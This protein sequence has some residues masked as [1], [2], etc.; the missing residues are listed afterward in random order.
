MLQV[1]EAALRVSVQAGVPQRLLLN[2]LAEYE[3]AA[4]LYP[5]SCL[6]SVFKHSGAEMW[7]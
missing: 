1:D 4:L 2:Y 3:C 5:C 6:S 7:E